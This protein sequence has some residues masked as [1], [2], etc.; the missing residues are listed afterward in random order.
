MC[1]VQALTVMIGPWGGRGGTPR[2][3]NKGNSISPYRLESITI[4]SSNYFGGRINGFSFIYT[5]IKG[6]SIT[7]GTWGSATNGNEDTVRFDLTLCMH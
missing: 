3:I 1:M 6:Q 7:V 5:D 4:R 2:D